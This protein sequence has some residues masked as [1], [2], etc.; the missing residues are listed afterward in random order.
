MN[1]T[2]VL[3][4][5]FLLVA[6]IVLGEYLARWGL[7]VQHKY[8]VWRPYFRQESGLDAQA[9]PNFPSP[10]R[11]FV[12][13]DG[14]RGSEVPRHAP[15]LYRALVAGGS[16]V[17]CYALDQ[18]LSWPAVLQRIL[19][20]PE[21]LKKLGA[22]HVHVG[23]IGKS[24]VGSEM[25]SFI[26]RHVLQRLP[27]L[28]VIIIMV[29]ATDAVQWLH[30]GAPLIPP[31]VTI[32]SIEKQ[33]GCH[34]RGPFGPQLRRTALAEVAH[35]I[36]RA[37]LRPTLRHQG[38]GSRLHRVRQMRANA[39]EVRTAVEHPE[40]VVNHFECHFRNVLRTAQARTSRLIVARQPWLTEPETGKQEWEQLWHG[41][42]GYVF[43]EEVRVF[44]STQ[45]VCRCMEL[46]DECATAVAREL[47]VECYELRSA[48]EPSFRSYHDLFHF[49]PSGAA[50]VAGI[51]ADVVVAG[52][53]TPVAE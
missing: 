46:I 38:Y 51:L 7:W 28:D 25:L 3:L 32:E 4:L 40:V 10:A 16:A 27:R 26:L 8:C 9:F 31:A 45:V 34:P 11:F 44:Y 22:T 24:G 30:A 36:Y 14:E 2:G 35:R 12:N 50:A 53:P 15:S 5:L 37:V 49:T 21:N 41:A 13:R 42:V 47:G 48:I 17:E 6:I 33:L 52:P 20:R 43:H 18:E 19:E 29:G 39:L 1:S 23:N